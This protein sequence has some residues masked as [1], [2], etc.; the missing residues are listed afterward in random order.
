MIA[1]I[2]SHQSEPAEPI[3]HARFLAMLPAIRRQAKIAFRNVRTEL[4]AELVQEVIANCLSAYALL[5]KHG[6]EDVAYP[7][8]LARFAVAHVRAGRR[9]GNRRSSCDVTSPYAQH[10][11]GF[12]VERLDSFNE[13]D[14]SWHE[15]IVEDKRAT[16]AD[17]AACRLDF[18]AWLKLLPGQRRK[19]ALTLAGG[20]TTGATARKFGVTAARISQIRQLLKES[21]ERFQGEGKSGEPQLAAA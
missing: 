10:C 14:D 2:Q 20:E 4:R 16:P 18:S 17:V 21:W 12:V 5:V 11:R 7:S 15:I 8:S 6:K 1:M 3:W 19:I 13:Q 9:V